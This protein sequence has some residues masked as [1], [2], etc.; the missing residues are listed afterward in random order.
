MGERS[1]VAGLAGR[2]SVRADLGGDL[3]LV[4][5]L[6]AQESAETMLAQATSIPGRGVVV[7]D[8]GVPGG[9]ERRP[10]R[11]LPRPWRRV[12]RDGHVPKPK[13][14]RLSRVCPSQ[15]AMPQGL[16]GMS[17]SPCTTGRLH[18]RSRRCRATCQTKI[19]LTSFCLSRHF[20]PLR[21]AAQDGGSSRGSRRSRWKS[22]GPTR[23]SMHSSTRPA[24]CAGMR[25]RAR[26]R[27]RWRSGRRA[28]PCW[29][30]APRC[31]SSAATSGD[32]WSSG[33]S[34]M[35]PGACPWR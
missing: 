6:G 25:S 21:T 9:V 10:R 16:A 8:A 5:R 34:P 32:N 3:E 14:G 31:P 19:S 2:C 11:P 24:G 35:L 22:A 33:P 30:L 26:S 13:T 28:S 1:K 12:H 18:A 29:D 23:C 15:S 4:A 17:R 20:G 27:R 7:A